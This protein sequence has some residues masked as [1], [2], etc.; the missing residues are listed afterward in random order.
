MAVQI[1]G[2]GGFPQPRLLQHVYELAGGDRV[3]VDHA[4]SPAFDGLPAEVPGELTHFSFYPWPPE[5]LRGP[6]HT[7]FVD[8]NPLYHFIVLVRSPLLGQVPEAE[9]YIAVI[10]MTIAGSW[11]GYRMFSYFRKRIAY[12]G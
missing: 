2:F 7:I 3:L 1:V 5:D 12:W 11:A 4:A 10:L 6:A 9:S 8:L